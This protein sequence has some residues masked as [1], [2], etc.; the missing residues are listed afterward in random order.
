MGSLPH[1]Q[2]QEHLHLYDLLEAVI[3]L[4]T[5]ESFVSIHCIS[6]PASG[7]K[8]INIRIRYRNMDIGGAGYRNIGMNLDHREH[9]FL[10]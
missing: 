3:H 8:D 4:L 1:S 10:K 6:G 7:T 5:K 9:S 2:K